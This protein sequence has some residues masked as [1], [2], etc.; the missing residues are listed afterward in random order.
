MKRARDSGRHQ[1]GRLR[2][3]PE[4]AYFAPPLTTVRQDFGEL[5]RRA[6]ELLVEELTG[7]GHARSHV[8]I[9]PEMVLRRSA[10]TVARR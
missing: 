2:R 3:H 8:L 10:G 5:G 9:S 1:R 6:L 7:V 4:A